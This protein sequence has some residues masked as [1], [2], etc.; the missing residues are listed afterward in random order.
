[1]PI[2]R[3]AWTEFSL[4]FRHLRSGVPGG[5]DFLWLT[6]L[7][8][9]VLTLGLLLQATRVG[10]LER[11]VDVFLGTVEEHGV[12]IWVIPNPVSKGSIKFISNDVIKEVENGGLR[13]FPY[14]E[15]DQGFG[16]VE[17]PS[18]SIWKTQSDLS[19]K[20]SG[21]AVYLDDPL[22]SEPK[23]ESGKL[24]LKIVINRALFHKHF[25]HR[26]YNEVM[27]NKISGSLFSEITDEQFL[28]RKPTEHLWLNI[29]SGNSSS[30]QKFEVT[31]RDRIPT[32]RNIVFLFPMATYHALNEASHYPELRYFPEYGGDAGYRLRRITISGDLE[33]ENFKKFLTIT[34]GEA[35][36][37]R[38]KTIVAFKSPQNKF[39]VKALL[40]D[41]KLTHRDLEV[42]NGH[43]ITDQKTHVELPCEI[44][45]KRELK[46]LRT[47]RV[48]GSHCR[49]L[50]DVTSSGNGFLRAFIYVPD[51]TTLNIAVQR[52]LE[53][54][55]Q[56]LSIHPIYKDALN[57]FGFLTKIIEALRWPY[58]TILLLFLISVLGIQIG[59]LVDH[60]RGRYGIFLAKGVNWLELYQM[61]YMQIGFALFIGA[62]G[63]S[64]I[65]AIV[66][67]AVSQIVSST[68]QEFQNTLNTTNF[69]I[70]PFS[71][72][73]YAMV[74]FGAFLL[75]QCF[76]TIILYRL[77][78]HS[79][80]E[81]GPM[82]QN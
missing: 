66:K 52:S 13:I 55:D 4:P 32:I 43:Q 46:K 61:L 31:W 23:I 53:I 28:S 57:R 75:A 27:R 67:H 68:T 70:L 9:L 34:K 59:T 21:W 24:P 78:I 6:S 50:K 48:A 37:R 17:L 22:W 18:R 76:A 19:P 15:I 11:F 58:G 69:E 42:V 1:M 45:P 39:L 60:R 73:D 30:L 62:V 26:Q 44:I 47:N 77:P 25:D 71:W 10:L 29:R 7:L 54:H 64:I 63:A 3:L 38:G 56:A 35:F 41:M 80:T 5:R 14:R 49:G 40:S 8:M 74:T 79:R 16:P 36:K 33:H 72:I 82:L 20:F 51:R 81:I 2:F 12:P 65:I